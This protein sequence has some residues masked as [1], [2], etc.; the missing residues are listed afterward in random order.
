MGAVFGLFG[1]F[2]HWISLV[3]GVFYSKFWGN[4]HFWLVFFS[5]NLTFFP[6][7]FLGLSGMPRRIPDYPDIY[8]LWNF[9]A[10]VGA[11]M[12]MFSIILFIF[13]LFSMFYKIYSIENINIFYKIHKELNNIYIIERNYFYYYNEIIYFFFFCKFYQSNIWKIEYL[14]L[15]LDL[16]KEENVINISI[17]RIFSIINEVDIDDYL[18]FE[19]NIE[20]R[21]F[22]FKQVLFFR[23]FC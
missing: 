14:W 4:F 5:V 16:I 6:M 10:S 1:A 22:N 15:I 3:K 9:I 19:K 17:K 18:F 21:Y 20:N 23:L 2:Y 7:H 11:T 8:F 13:I 12:S